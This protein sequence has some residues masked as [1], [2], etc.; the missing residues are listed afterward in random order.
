MSTISTSRPSRWASSRPARATD[1]GSVGLG[2]DGHAD[3]AAQ[4]PELLDGGRA[5]EVGPDE[6]GVAALLLE[7]AGQL[8]GGGRLARALEAGQHARRSAG[9]EA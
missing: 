6:H 1:T 4:D 3:L 7:P 2:E 5:L 9:W 8:A